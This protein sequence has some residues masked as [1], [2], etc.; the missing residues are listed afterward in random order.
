MLLEGPRVLATA[1]ESGAEILFVLRDSGASTLSS[2]SSLTDRLFRS[3]TEVTDVSPEAIKE[4]A[5][6][7]NPQGILGVAREPWADLPVDEARNSAPTPTRLLVLDGVQDPGNA[8]T[9]VRAA[10]GLGVDRVFALDGTVDLWSPKAVRA[11]AGFGFSI[12]IHQVDWTAARTWLG[13]A[14]VPLLVADAGGDD[15]RRWSA[16][17][18]NRGSD[19]WALLL[20]NE[21]AGPREEALSVAAARLAI[22]LWPGVDS[23]NVAVAGAILIWALGPAEELAQEQL[24]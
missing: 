11:S 23:L 9:L 18:E 1:A 3:G 20:G 15:I 19:H 16:C 4:F 22:P 17:P 2:L 24:Q 5:E 8:G 13:N 14:E 21:T 10:A 7:D 12:P 6:T